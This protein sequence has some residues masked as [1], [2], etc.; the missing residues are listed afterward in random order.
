MT[1]AAAGNNERDL[2]HYKMI[3]F[4]FDG[5]LA[6]SHGFF[7]DAMDTL[8]RIHRFRRIDR[9][10]LDTLRNYDARQMMRHVG[11]PFWKMSCVARDFR[12]MMAQQRA[13]IALFDGIVPALHQLTQA[14]LQLAMLTSNSEEN[15]R[16]ILGEKAAALFHY[17]ECG[18]SIFGKRRKLRRLLAASG[19]PRDRVLCVGDEI[20]DIQAAHAERVDFAAVAWGYTAPAALQALAP[21]MVVHQVDELVQ[22]LI[23]TVAPAAGEPRSDSCPR[24]A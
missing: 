6:D 11:M 21:R 14:G 18:A 19:M 9:S 8:A 16:A 4:D 7:L 22:R 23:G 12:K 20:R 3:V 5:T 1:P 24:Q 10:E 13:S 15:V 2:M 17:Y